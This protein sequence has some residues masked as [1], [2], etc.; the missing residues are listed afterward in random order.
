M[1]L[2][3]K[4][5]LPFT[6]LSVAAS[7]EE[8]IWS[9]TNNVFDRIAVL[10]QSTQEGELVIQELDLNANVLETV[11]QAVAAGV[12]LKIMV[13]CATESIRVRFN[14]LAVSAATITG[15]IAG[16]IL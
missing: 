8:T 5:V 9:T 14:N 1:S 6:D 4:T 12:A 7:A 10:I 3:L 2:P 13:D 11:R 16:K 15:S